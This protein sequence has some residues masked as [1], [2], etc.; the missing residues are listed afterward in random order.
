MGLRLLLVTCLTIVS[1]SEADTL[2]DGTVDDMFL[3]QKDVHLVLEQARQ[4][5]EAEE[6]VIQ[7]AAAALPKNPSSYD[8]ELKDAAGK[9]LA[10][11]KTEGPMM[12]DLLQV[13]EGKPTFVANISLNS[14]A[15]TTTTTSDSGAV[16]ASITFK[17][18]TGQID[19]KLEVEEVTIKLTITTG[20]P[21]KDYWSLS[22]I[23]TSVVATLNIGETNQKITL[24][25]LDLTP[26]RGY[27]NSIADAACTNGYGI[28]APVWLSWTCSN[29]ILSPLA[30]TEGPYSARLLLSGLYLQS[31]NKTRANNWDC[32]PLIPISLW[33]SLL[34]SLLLIS[35]L[36]YGIAMISSIHTPDKYDDP[37]GPSIS[38]GLTE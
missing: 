35:I 34:I 30:F 32:D 26:K 17:N 22:N 19:P 9:T 28:C 20:T 14:D 31:G 18:L 33:V 27:T 1:L 15:T 10:R 24:T 36:T 5:R 37:K 25:D 6:P 21:K 29:Q 2:V 3:V 8:Y 38:V 7:P 13:K 23:T 12:V 4:K 11:L 16:L